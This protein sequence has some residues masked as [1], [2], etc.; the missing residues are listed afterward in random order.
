M[1]IGLT[2]EHLDLRD[3]VRAFVNRHITE[4]TL[5]AAADAER[6][7][8][9]AHWSGLAEQ[10][11]LGLHLP[12]EDGGAGYGLVEL[13]VVTEELG[14]ATAPGPFLPTTLASAV[15]HAAGHRTYLA[16][17]AVGT[18]L[19]AVGLAPGTL[20]LARA[21]DGGVTVTGTSEL[22]I[23]GH[24]A[25]V[26]V[27]PASDNGRTTWLVLP[28]AAVDTTDVRSHDLT[29][30]SSRVTVRSV[31]VP[32]A[33]LLDLDPRTPGDLAATLF[34]AEAA[35]LADR[36]VTTA[37]QYARV[38][39]QF[40]RRIGQFQGVKHR[41]A[42]MLAQAEQARACAW[43]AARAHGA[44]NPEEATLAAAVAAAVGVDAA[45]AVAKDC[46]Q[47]LGGIGFTWEH[48]AHLA[49][50]RA[51]TLRIA[52]GPA[53]VWRRRV[54]RLALDGTRR[55]LGVELPPEAET[56]REDIRAELRAA[57]A[58]DGK[59]RLTHLADH[60]YTAP[61]L[62]A[63]WGKGAG[64]VD[65]LVIAEELRAADLTPVD[66]IIGGWV[67]PTLIAHGDPTQQERFLA[68]SLRGDIIWCQLFSEP[69]AGSDLAGLTTRAEKVDGGWRITGQ[70][71]WTSMARDAHWGVLLARTDADVPKH[72]G[73]SYFLLDM[74]SPGLD[75]RPLRQITGDAEFNEVFLDEVFV[76]DDLLVGSPGAG[77]KLART[78]LA[79]ERVALSHDSVGSGAEA[80]L[81]IAAVSDGLDDEQLTTLG[82]HLCDAQTGAV[83]ALRT[84]LRTVSGQQPGAEASV[85]KLLGVEHQQR[86]WETCMDWQGAA[87][88]TGEGERLD[89]TWQFL[90]AR[91]L[92]IAGGTT[93]VQL[94]II[95]ERMLGLP[96]DPEPTEKG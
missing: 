67:V 89:A 8:L 65:Q 91:C 61:H 92:S 6:E 44:G 26:F 60:G 14:R 9:P 66:M 40:G 32:A 73:I 51:Q 90:N 57:A 59:E 38:R 48:D 11:V 16:P 83:L 52:L 41:C 21:A 24:L 80:L 72:K 49:L 1:T 77:W 68:P 4:D 56:V 78:T 47:V 39:E 79:N 88:L 13:A 31:P 82:A 3:A 43:D 46:I 76:P 64:P 71:V 94:N 70:K 54:A 27:L 35:G 23:G 69:G 96:R 17:L 19:G 10:G 45:F 85:S 12:E 37:A 28:R 63:P 75:I 15:L 25:D 33:D 7:T 53:A 29:R 36:C 34:A 87:A 86:V 50:R 74:T 55:T 18:T 95:G 58:L 5:R 93:E 42:R 81:E 20:A 62:P 30:R 22:V 2:Q 84:T